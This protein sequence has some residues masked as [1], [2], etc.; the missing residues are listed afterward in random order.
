M[1][2]LIFPPSLLKMFSVADDFDLRRVKSMQMQAAFAKNCFYEGLCSF[3]RK[4]IKIN[5][6]RI[7]RQ[8]LFLF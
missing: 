1:S 4:V 6:E 5:A 7:L 2:F 3:D 8:N